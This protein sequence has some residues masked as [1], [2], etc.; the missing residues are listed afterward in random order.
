MNGKWLTVDEAAK[1]MATKLDVSYF[2]I[3]TL[4]REIK[5][6]TLLAHYWPRNN[7]KLGLFH[8]QPDEYGK[9]LYGTDYFKAETGWFTAHGTPTFFAEIT[10]PIPLS[11][12]MPFLSEEVSVLRYPEDQEK[13]IKGITATILAMTDPVGCYGVGEGNEPIS[14]DSYDYLVLIH[15]EELIAYEKR[16]PL[17]RLIRTPGIELIMHDPNGRVRNSFTAN[18]IQYGTIVS[19]TSDKNNSPE[20]RRGGSWHKTLALAAHVIA[21]LCQEL[22]SYKSIPSKKHN[23]KTKSDNSIK[24]QPLAR[25]LSQK[26]AQLELEGHGAGHRGFEERLREALKH[27]S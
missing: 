14:L 25:L 22:D 3:E 7:E 6:N 23:I 12:A 4:W 2:A 27:L 18:C 26:A 8:F 24:I 17:P 15:I 20:E 19:E 1:W 21:D 16:Y 13:I 11:N 9:T 10:G 5:S